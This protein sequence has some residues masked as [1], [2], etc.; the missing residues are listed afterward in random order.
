MWFSVG[1]FELGLVGVLFVVTTALAVLG[2]QAWR[3]TMI[4][5]VCAIAATICTPADP[6]STIILGAVFAMFFIGGIRFAEQR[7]IVGEVDGVRE[8][9]A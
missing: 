5:L 9:T 8:R 1:I 3:W 2:V 6:L 7:R 4:G